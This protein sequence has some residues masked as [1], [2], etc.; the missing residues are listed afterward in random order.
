MLERQRLR[1]TIKVRVA[2][3]CF[4]VIL[5]QQTSARRRCRAEITPPFA[6]FGALIYTRDANINTSNLHAASIRSIDF[7]AREAFAA[8]RVHSRG[9][10]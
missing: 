10:D 4:Y 8:S 7:A 5:Q 2:K 3:V 1:E 6:P 9:S